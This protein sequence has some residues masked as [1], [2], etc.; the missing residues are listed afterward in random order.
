VFGVY[1]SGPMNWARPS[2]AEIGNKKQMTNEPRLGGRMNFIT[3]GNMV[4]SLKGGITKFWLET[5]LLLLFGRDLWDF[6]TK[7]PFLV[8]N[9]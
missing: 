2:R 9:F 5:L 4:I 8:F 3:G 7:S 1:L 6:L